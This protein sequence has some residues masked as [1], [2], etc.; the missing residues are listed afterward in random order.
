LPEPTPLFRSSNRSPC[1]HAFSGGCVIVC[2]FFRC[3]PA[4]QCK[5]LSTRADAKGAGSVSTA[6]RNADQVQAADEARGGPPP[7]WFTTV[8]CSLDGCE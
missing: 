7:P 6:D 3:G 1:R 2:N 8:I 5:G 4:S